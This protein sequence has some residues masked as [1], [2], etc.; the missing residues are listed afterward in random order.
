M[1]WQ[2][3]KL[4]DDQG[5]FPIALV[6]ETELDSTR[7]DFLGAGYTAVI[8]AKEWLSLRFESFQRPDDVFHR[9]LRAIVPARF[10]AK[11]KDR[12]GAVLRY[13]DGFGDQPVLREGF[14]CTAGEQC[15]DRAAG[16]RVALGDERI[17]TVECSLYCEPQRATPGCIRIDIIEVREIRRIL[18]RTVHGNGMRGLNRWGCASGTGYIAQ[19][20][21]S[22]QDAERGQVSAH[23]H[24]SGSVLMLIMSAGCGS[25]CFGCVTRFPW[26]NVRTRMESSVRCLPGR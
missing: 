14:V 10:R 2:N 5:K 3:R 24:G 17:K 15:L 26:W 7:S 23:A 13:L 22:E 21:C 19:H 9:D 16:A 20:C 8:E 18:W 1:L 25:R 4:A 11:R 12:P 6:G